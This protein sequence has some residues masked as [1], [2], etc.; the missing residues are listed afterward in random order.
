MRILLPLLDLMLLS[1]DVK[2]EASPDSLLGV[3]KSEMYKKRFYDSQKDRRVRLFKQQ[4]RAISLTN[5]AARYALCHDL[6]EE[7][8][9]H[10]FD[11]AYVYALRLNQISKLMQ[12]ILLS[13]AIWPQVTPDRTG[14][15]CLST[16]L[17]VSLINS[18]CSNPLRAG[19]NRS[20]KT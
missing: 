20:S 7:Y 4:Q 15:T 13:S 1:Y 12:N 8:K 2:C 11:S 6:Y 3:L 19:F 16:T 14:D 9:N 10:V 5:L 17:P 18:M